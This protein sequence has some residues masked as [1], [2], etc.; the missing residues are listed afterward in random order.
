[1]KLTLKI[2]K[3][4]GLVLGAVLLLFCI[5]LGVLTITE[6][7]P[8][9][10]QA[11]E[12]LVLT[13][14][15]KDAPK[16]FTVCTWNIGYGGLGRDSDFFMDGGKMVYPP[17]ENSVEE[18]LAAITA[19]VEENPA[20]VWF[21]QEVDLD[22]SRS[23]GI[24]QYD[25]MQNTVGGNSAFA[26][27]YKCAFVPYPLPPIG[28]V[29]S[30][31]AT[32]TTLAMTMDAQRIAMPSPFKWPVRVANLKRCLLVS[33]VPVEGSDKELVLVNLHLEA[34]SSD[35]AR[36]EQARELMALLEA[37]YEKGNY[38]IAGGDFNQSMPG[39][40][41]AFPVLETKYWVPGQF[42]EDALAEG[43][44]CAAD[45]SGATCRLLNAPYSED[46]QL[47]VIDGFIVSPNVE[48]VSVE[49]VALDFQNSDHNPVR[50]QVELR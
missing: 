34:Y 4:S 37:E 18:N 15:E 14:Q 43:W 24:D 19:F 5:L 20:D 27:N 40:R 33:R 23:G 29:Q 10:R 21:L 42:E 38:V 35:E 30:G 50:M 32:Y 11:A 39:G 22:S 2:L 41:D 49:T 31:V 46:T 3:V 8:D 17:D 45:T 48:V 47:Y 28:K 25:L 36:M 16:S 44:C 1:M 9:E 13:T 7:R 6:Y 26:Y 12:R